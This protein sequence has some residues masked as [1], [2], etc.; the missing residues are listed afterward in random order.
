MRKLSEHEAYAQLLGRLSYSDRYFSIHVLKYDHGMAR[1]NLCYKKS[2]GSFWK[3]YNF[4]ANDMLTFD[5]CRWTCCDDV[6]E[7]LCFLR[8]H[9]VARKWFRKAIHHCIK[10]YLL[11]NGELS[12][13]LAMDDQ[14]DRNSRQW[15]FVEMPLSML[16]Y[17]DVLTNPRA[18]EMYPWKTRTW[19]EEKDDYEWEDAEPHCKCSFVLSTERETDVSAMD[20]K[21]VPFN[22]STGGKESKCGTIVLHYSVE[23]LLA[24]I[25]QTNPVFYQDLEK[26]GLE[27]II[28][29]HC[30]EAHEGHTD[31]I[32]ERIEF[33]V[34]VFYPKKTLYVIPD[35]E[36]GDLDDWY[37]YH[38]KW[39][40]CSRE[41]RESV[42][43]LTLDE[44]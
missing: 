10:D 37:R 34:E 14:C 11:P 30:R 36:D 16:G 44:A 27:N 7:C 1:V 17:E 23:E 33:N 6:Y 21:V 3:L 35:L 12:G 38:K 5:E 42:P 9:K 4:P 15:R 18:F 13:D 29:I 25:K 31:E 24:I 43:L 39:G 41:V 19:N 32:P 20:I 28:S 40:E 26:H 22:E 2:H 8:K